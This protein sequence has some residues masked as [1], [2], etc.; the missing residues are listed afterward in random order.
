MPDVVPGSAESR[1]SIPGQSGVSSNPHKSSWFL[2]RA[3][4][5]TLRLFL[6]NYS[7]AIPKGD[8]YFH[9]GCP[10]NPRE[11]LPPELR[12]RLQRGLGSP[13]ALCRFSPKLKVE[14]PSPGLHRNPKPSDIFLESLV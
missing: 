1:L 14:A 10:S 11:E 4:G 9:F 12:V 6:E 5:K 13:E 2:L 3:L 8:S 7:Y